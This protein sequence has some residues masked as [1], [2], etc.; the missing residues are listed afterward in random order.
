MNDTNTTP[1]PTVAFGADQVGYVLK[2]EIIK[3]LKTMG[4]IIEDFGV[5]SSDPVDYP[6]IAGRVAE[7]VAEG[8]FDRGV[9]VCG[10][11]LGMSIAAN[12]VRG[13]RAGVCSE[14]YSAKMARAHNDAQIICIGARVVGYGLG[15]EIVRS[16]L[17]TGYDGG[18]HEPRVSKIKAMDGC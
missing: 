9:L 4:Y 6:D 8:R 10:T 12:K 5:F 18:R 17:E 11:G 1:L 3:A 2:D 16:F 13:I 15:L 7:A 14:T